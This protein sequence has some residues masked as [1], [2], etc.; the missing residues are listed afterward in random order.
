MP[1]QPLI[2][3][4]EQDYRTLLEL[5]RREQQRVR[6]P[7][8]PRHVVHSGPN[9]QVVKADDPLSVT[10]GRWA[11]HWFEYDPAAKTYTQKNEV[12]L[13]THNGGTP[14]VAWYYE[15]TQHGYEN[16]R[17]VFAIDD[18]GAITTAESDGSPSYS[19]HTLRFNQTDGFSVFSSTAGIVD[20]SIQDAGSGIVGIVNA[21]TQTFTGPKTI[22]DGTMPFRVADG[23]FATRTLD[24]QWG[25]DLVEFEFNNVTDDAEA[26]LK[27]FTDGT[28]CRAVLTGIIDLTGTPTAVNPTYSVVDSASAQHNGAWGTVSGLVFKAGLYISGTVT[29]AT[30]ADGDYGD[31]TVSGTGTALT[32][33]NGVVTYA[34]MQD[35]SATDK[36]L[37]RSTAG[38][39][40]VEEITCTAAGRALLDDASATDQR[41]TLG[42]G[43]A[44]VKNTGTSGN[45]VPLLDGANTWSA[46]QTISI[47][48]AETANTTN[49]FIFHHSS[50]GTPAAGF[51]V[52]VAFRLEST[53]NASRV[54]G[55]FDAV[56]ADP[57][58]ATRKGRFVFYVTDTGNR[59]FLRGQASGTAAMIG[60]LGASAA[61]QQTGDAGTALVT[62]GLMSGTPTFAAA[63]ISG[64]TTVGRAVLGST[65][66]SAITFLRANADN[67][68]TWLNA[69]DFRTAIGAGAG[70]VTDFSA[71]DLSPLF[72]TTEATTTTT[73][74]LTF[75]LTNQDA[76]KFFGGPTSGG[77]GAPTVR[78]LV[79]ADLPLITA[80]T[81]DDVAAA[82]YLWFADASASNETNRIRLDRL[83]GWAA[84][85]LF[86]ARLTLTSGSPVADDPGNGATIYL[87]PYKGNRVGLYD[88]TRWIEY[89]LSEI[90]LALTVTSGS[91][92]DVWLYDNA[93]TLTLE[94]LVWTNTTTRATA[95]ATQDG[96]YVKSGATTRRYV[97]TIWASGNNQTTDDTTVR[98][99]WNYYNRIPKRISCQPIDD[100]HTYTTATWRQW[101]ATDTGGQTRIEFVSGV[102]EDAIVVMAHGNC[103]NANEPWSSVGI[104]IDA[105]N[106]NSALTMGGFRLPAQARYAGHPGIGKHAMYLLQYSAVSGTTTW[107]GDAGQ[108]TVTQS[109]IVGTIFC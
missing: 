59:E 41:T 74:A 69:S 73:P 72:T 24:F 87:A 25:T 60:F 47:E 3:L 61:V 16:S 94:T 22:T 14:N 40:D 27:L 6:D 37:G 19:T 30:L 9:L 33:D 58:D 51:G 83:A 67:T 50:T 89:V 78:A 53:T 10:S 107:Y 52:N 48:D 28:D 65:N 108:P 12:W 75:V 77:A 102:K 71:G 92:Y 64:S 20:V 100:S 45:N 88:G 35:V 86:Q 29:G 101:N 76:N 93:G 68:V 49:V 7:G 79:T 105:T 18:T 63:N 104:G 11:G 81:E 4:S 15:P 103:Y 91:V 55:A 46:V 54:C 109:G 97:G 82:D 17:P 39:G 43:T 34:K 90:S 70:T 85:D 26:T 80:A 38:A 13:V 44:A 57:A 5:V 42:L 95:L 23:D 31:I 2:A 36:L 84:K 106:A 99:V 8:P 32:I 1:D 56:W 96:I 66:P 62:F 98:G 21:S